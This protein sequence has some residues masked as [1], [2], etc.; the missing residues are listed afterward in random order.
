MTHTRTPLAT[1]ATVAVVALLNAC[2]NDNYTT[3]KQGRTGELITITASQG[4]AD[5]TAGTRLTH[6]DGNP[7]ATNGKMTIQWTAPTNADTDDAFML[8]DSEGGILF[9]IQSVADGGTTATFQGQKPKDGDTY[10]AFYPAHKAKDIEGNPLPWDDCV[11]DMTGQKQT[12]DNTEHLSNYHYMTASGSDY[13]SLSFN[14]H[15]AILKFVV[16]LPQNEAPTMLTLATNGIIRSQKIDG[17]DA[18]LDNELSLE[19]LGI[20]TNSFTAYMA[21]LPFEVEAGEGYAVTITTNNGKMYEYLTDNKDA[22]LFEAEKAYNIALTVNEPSG[23]LKE[24]S[25]TW[26]DAIEQSARLLGTGKDATHPYLIRHA[27]DLKSFFLKEDAGNAA[28]YSE[29]EANANKFYKLTH[30]INIATTSW[31]VRNFYGNFDG[32]QHAI[33]GSMTI[34]TA[35]ADDDDEYMGFFGRL[36]KDKDS[37]PSVSNLTISADITIQSGTNIRVGG[38]CGGSSFAGKIDNCHNTG[39]ITCTSTPAF[40][41]IGGLSGVY[42]FIS[43][44]TNRGTIDTGEGA[45]GATAGGICGDGGVISGCKNIGTGAIIA[46]IVCG[47]ANAGG[48]CGGGGNMSDCKNTSTGAITAT[49]TSTV[50]V[51]SVYAGGIC[52]ATNGGAIWQCDNAGTGSITATASSSS[53]SA[54][55]GGICGRYTPDGYYGPYEDTMYQCNNT[56]TGAITATATLAYA[57]GICG[58]NGSYNEYN[59]NHYHANIFDS[60][61]SN[62]SVSAIGST[63]SYAGSISGYNR[64]KIYSCCTGE[65]G[66]S[67]TKLIGN[68]EGWTTDGCPGG[69]HPHDAD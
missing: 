11:F 29:N 41:C 6:A 39:N 69:T 56:G 36:L 24:V 43:N 63:K 64:T 49:A 45:I 33:G 30:N 60:H 47:T 61:N 54:T 37:E 4:T 27:N 16:T 7:L 23:N 52:G 25:Y 62:T 26:G 21:I 8:Y 58:E 38:I 1:L 28:V 19:L 46:T 66:G 34:N 2:S 35:T 13:N 31:T 42:G 12:G 67:L 50:E 15:I 59:P 44:C 20:T 65:L 40:I 18:T 57:G 53:S 9:T 55:A 14:A 48:I 10:K 5:N 17:S 22:K 32:S 68:D 51:S 3:G